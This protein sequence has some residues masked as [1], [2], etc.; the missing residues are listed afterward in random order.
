MP[1]FLQLPI[2]FGIFLCC[3]YISRQREVE[4]QPPRVFWA[5]WRNAW[6]VLWG[7]GGLM[8]LLSIGLTAGFVLIGWDDAVQRWIQ[9]EAPLVKIVTWAAFIVGVIWTPLL[10]L[11]LLFWAKRRNYPRHIAGAAAAVQ[12]ICTTFWFVTTLK[13]ISGRRGPAW[14]LDSVD[15]NPFSSFT[16]AM[17]GADFNF[18]FWMHSFQDGRFFWPSGHTA[19]AVSLVAALVAF[20]PEK[21]WISWLGFPLTAFMAWA[22]LDGNHHWLSDIIAGWLLAHVIGHYIGKSFATEF[23]RRFQ[24]G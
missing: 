15:P 4:T 21:R 14:L 11:T 16:R 17:H 1:Y 6:C 12:S 8:L 24:K 20:Y 19:T 23:N 9:R 10:G 2:I 7:L 22:M 3:W 18:Y 13:I 5:F